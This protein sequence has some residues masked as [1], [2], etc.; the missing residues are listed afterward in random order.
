MI[1]GDGRYY[2]RHA[3]QVIV[4]MAAA[5]GIGR[6]LLGQAG[7]L[8]TPAASCI[9]RKYRAFGG[10]ILSASH[11]PGGPTEDFGIKYNTG[12]GGPAPE[13]CTNKIYAASQSIS[14][15]QI[16][17]S[18]DIDIDS[19]GKFQLG[20]LA[21]TV[22]DSVDD[23][24]QMMSR[25]F[26]FELLRNAL[27]TSSITM[28][29]D[30]M[31]AVTG[32]YAKRI[33]EDTLGAMP[34]SV[35]NAIPLEDFGGEH[36]DPNLTHAHVL[37]ELML[38]SNAPTFGAASDG[39]GDRNMI[40]GRHFFVTPSDS[41]AVLAANAH[42]VPG[43]KNGLSGVARS[44]PTS[45]A[46]DRVAESFGIQSYETPT[47]GSFFG[48]LLDANRITM[49]GEESFGQALITSVKKTDYGRF[50]SGSIY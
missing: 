36:P 32:P 3:I 9:I 23:Y 38:G 17:D 45:R 34:G 21:I 4:K 41:L 50:Y 22:M 30:A 16:I 14:E 43:Y 48:N 5:N 18:P 10:I 39:D 7:I 49:C 35:V 44:M 2:N 11:N 13:N 29:F 26:D 31:H 27:G 1:G 28:C 25:L 33:F 19:I 8:S 15:Y 47:D 46:V 42:L 40:F 6:I 12:N 24:A 37:A 20:D